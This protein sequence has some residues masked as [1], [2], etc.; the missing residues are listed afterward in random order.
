MIKRKISC[1]AS[2]LLRGS[3]VTIK[4]ASEGA[5]VK[6]VAGSFRVPHT[7]CPREGGL[8]CISTQISRPGDR[9]SLNVLACAD[10]CCFEPWG[11]SPTNRY[12]ATPSCLG[13]DDLGEATPQA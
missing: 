10:S 3:I 2:S 12:R 13:G 7:G 1:W 8:D 6:P 9:Q 5:W 4:D 11:I